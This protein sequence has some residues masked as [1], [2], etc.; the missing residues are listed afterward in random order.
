MNGKPV[1]FHPLAVR[2]AAEAF[3][4][5]AARNESVAERFA[6]ELDRAVAAIATRPQSFP[7]HLAGT[8]R[9]VLGRYPYLVVFRELDTAIQVV[10]V[11]HGRRR[12]G[13]WR[14][15]LT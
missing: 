11:A 2:E 6:D 4:W 7:P 8:R 9:C 12:P 14:Q 5:Y 3:G 15:R 10:S 1:E 13:Y